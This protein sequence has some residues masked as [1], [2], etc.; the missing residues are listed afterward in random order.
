MV[1]Y[2]SNSYSNSRYSCIALKVYTCTGTAN[3]YM[4]MYVYT[5]PVKKDGFSC[6]TQLRINTSGALN[7][8][9]CTARRI[10]IQ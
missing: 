10:Y 2:S 4:Q 7:Y 6:Q 9:V 1:M 3:L 5:F 8:I